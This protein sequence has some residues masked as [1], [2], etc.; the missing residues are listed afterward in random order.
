MDSSLN[1]YRRALPLTIIFSGLFL[2]G[3]LPIGMIQGVATDIYLSIFLGHLGILIIAIFLSLLIF[4]RLSSEASLGAFFSWFIFV[5][6]VA[7]AVLNSRVPVTAR[8]S[9]IHHLAVPRWW[10]EN[11]KIGPIV[12]HEWSYY[13]M[14]L[15]LAFVPFLQRGLEPLTAVYHGAYLIITA[16]V[17][18]SFVFYKTKSHDLGLCGFLIT[19]TLPLCFRLA[20]LPIVDLGLA[21]FCSIALALAVYWAEG[22]RSLMNLLLIGVAMGLALGTKYN[23]LLALFWFFP[24]FI[25]MAS[26]CGV[27]FFKVI[28]A[29]M[30]IGFFALVV[31][32]PWLVKNA[33]WISNP[34]YPQ[35]SNFFGPIEEDPVDL[36]VL[37][38]FEERLTL[39]HDT[40]RDLVLT[41]FSMILFGQDDDPGRFDG[42]LSP[43]LL[44]LF[45]PL[46]KRRGKPWVIFLA[47]FSFTYFFS[48]TFMTAARVRYYIPLLLPVIA[49]TVAG[50]YDVSRLFR[51]HEKKA[52]VALL[53][54]HLA[55]AGVYAYQLTEKTES[56][57]YAFSTETRADYLRRRV[58]E[59]PM[60]EYINQHLQPTDKVFL[61]FTGN[62]FYYYSVPVLSGG[63]YSAHPL[64]KLIKQSPNSK[65]L[66]E[67]LHHRGITYI[68]AHA[69]RTLDTFMASLTDKEKGLWN[70]FQMEHLTVTTQI[71]P[72]VLWRV[73]APQ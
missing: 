45:V 22:E 34:F 18:A 38:S 53:V 20:G 6:F 24:C 11:G 8:D 17:I 5:G 59:Y 65:L 60:I 12:W 43:L 26:R 67:E 40:W 19:L 42:L 66:A 57:A 54:A 16:G 48:A 73:D 14:L 50:M 25:L 32:G 41:P 68:M 47:L 51:G 13:P 71:G 46:W 2:L 7:L 62:K 37:S 49:L 36:P 29:C 44:L 21:L 28:F 4:A 31:D 27:G 3:L 69:P 33:S 30:C 15:N 58:S 1:S 10:I 63:H 61:L 9:L 23:A 70:E 72:W 56:V 35:F 64:L 52:V 55:F 39:H